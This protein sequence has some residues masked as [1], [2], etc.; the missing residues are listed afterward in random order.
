M[1]AAWQRGTAARERES[2][3]TKGAPRGRLPRLRPSFSRASFPSLLYPPLPDGGLSPRSERAARPFCRSNAGR[4]G[5]V[6]D[7]VV[8]VTRTARNATFSMPFWDNSIVVTYWQATV[9]MRES[10]AHQCLN[11]GRQCHCQTASR[12]SCARDRLAAG[13]CRDASETGTRLLVG[14]GLSEWAE[15]RRLGLWR[16]ASAGIGVC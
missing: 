13:A 9:P 4:E 8:A 14:V 3:E 2:L 10:S 5:Q 7:V 15:K 16:R 1:R 6:S 11:D 12:A